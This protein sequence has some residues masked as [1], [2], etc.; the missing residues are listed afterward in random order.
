MICSF[1]VFDYEVHVTDVDIK[2]KRKPHKQSRCFDPGC[3]PFTKQQKREYT[4]F[5]APVKMCVR[6][7]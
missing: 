4:W 2:K 5:E 1:N 7:V 3:H 6:M